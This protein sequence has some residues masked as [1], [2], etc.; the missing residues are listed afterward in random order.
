MMLTRRWSD[1]RV[2]QV[3]PKEPVHKA[4][5]AEG[6]AATRRYMQEMGIDT[7][8][9]D[10]AQKIRHEDIRYLSRDEIAAFGIDRR[11]FVETP[12]FFTQFSS[13]NAYVS[14]WIVEARGPDRKEYR[15]SVVMFRCSSAS[16]AGMNFVRGL[17]SDETERAAIATFSIGKQKLRLPLSSASKRDA[18]DTSGTFST[19]A[20]SVLLTELEAAAASEEAIRG[21]EGDPLLDTKLFNVFELSTHGLAASL[22]PLRERCTAPA[23]APS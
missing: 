10:A 19:G 14:K 12:W 7:A 6:V 21:T 23:Q 4:R 22:K 3:S 2:Q 17:A 13:G 16:R 9:M 8:L 20:S 18:I 5:A 15:V 1:G 11:A